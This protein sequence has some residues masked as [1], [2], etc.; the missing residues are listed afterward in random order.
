VLAFSERPTNAKPSTISA[1][2]CFKILSAFNSALISPVTC[3]E[4]NLLK[5]GPGAKF[6]WILWR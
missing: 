1:S 4:L 5:V 3:G 6:D 2:A